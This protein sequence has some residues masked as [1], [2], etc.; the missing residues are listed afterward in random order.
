LIGALKVQFRDGT[1]LDV[2]TDGQWES[3]VA[4]PTNWRTDVAAI[5]WAKAMEVGPLALEP[6]PFP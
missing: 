2:V 5:G 3:I 1:T 4:P 6:F